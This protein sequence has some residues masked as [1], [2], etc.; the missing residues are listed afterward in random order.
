V[1]NK[2]W[3]EVEVAPTETPKADVTP[4]EVAPEEEKVGHRAEKRIKQLLARVK[5]AEDRASR[6]ETE[7]AAKAKEA[8][9]ALEKAKGTESSAH[10]VYRNSLQD[11]IKVAEKRFQDAYDAADRDALLAAL[12][13]L[14]E[15][16]LDNRAL[17]AW[18]RSDKRVDTP[19]PPSPPQQQQ[20]VQLAPATKEWMDSN[21]WFGRGPDADRLATAA[22]VA[23]S[24]D[25]VAE[26]FDPNGTEFYEEVEKRLVAEMPR[27]SS[28]ISK[29]EPEPRKPVVAGQSRTPSRR[30]RLD[31]GTVRA[32]N[33]LGASLE[34]TARYM[35][36]IQ[37]AGEG[38]VNIDIKRGRK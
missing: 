7:A 26:G 30:I 11:K 13:D 29:G 17:E 37:D 32:S 35:E 23:I 27:M 1:E 6:A 9:E 14:N 2:E 21:P 36:K 4:V 22:A 16:S 15:A 24:D 38:Y 25:L 10:A 28:K 8:I 5:D 31:E 34:D 18:D 20:Q 3:V 33:R 12:L 19:P